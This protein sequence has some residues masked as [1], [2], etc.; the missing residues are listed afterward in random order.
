M[1]N[2]GIGYNCCGRFKKNWFLCW[3]ETLYLCKMADLKAEGWVYQVYMWKPFYFTSVQK[4]ILICE[5][6]FYSYEILCSIWLW[7]ESVRCSVWK[8][9]IFVPLECLWCLNTLLKR[10]SRCRHH[11]IDLLVGGNNRLYIVEITILIWI[12]LVICL[13]WSKKPYT[14]LLGQDYDT[15]DAVIEKEITYIFSYFYRNERESSNVAYMKQYDNMST[16][17]FTRYG[18]K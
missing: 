5:Q 14:R 3:S 2:Y 1:K 15:L 16:S 9:A 13:G 17:C 12:R 4:Y 7:V 6:H 11:R 8:V 18:H 10:P